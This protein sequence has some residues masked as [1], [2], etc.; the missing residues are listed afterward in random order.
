MNLEQRLRILEY[1][2]CL[3]GKGGSNG[4]GSGGCD[5]IDIVINF[6]DIVLD[7]KKRFILV[8]TNELDNGNSSLYLYTGLEL[9]F[10]I[11]VP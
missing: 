3:L 5:C 11:T 10:L 7:N 2:M 6:P 4:Y 9:K 8:I 1:K